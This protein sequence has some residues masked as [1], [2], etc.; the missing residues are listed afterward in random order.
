MKFH[1]FVLDT[2]VLISAAIVPHSVPAQLL[3]RVLSEATLL[4]SQ[5]INHELTRILLND[6]KFGSRLTR[7][8]RLAF[9]LN[10]IR[11]AES[12]NTTSHITR[13]RDDDDNRILEIALDGK[14]DVI[15]T[16]DQGLLIL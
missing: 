1:R 2:N 5:H 16:G 3:A 7:Q 4:T 12:I 15:V 8:A 10:L 6:R 13:C 14:A 9:V 11:A